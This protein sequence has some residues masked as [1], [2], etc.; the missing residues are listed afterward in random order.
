[1]QC[2]IKQERDQRAKA[3][4][5][6]EEKL[7]AQGLVCVRLVN[8]TAGVVQV[9]LP[10]C[11]VHTRG[12]LRPSSGPICLA[13]QV[14]NLRGGTADALGLLPLV[15]AH[16]LPFLAEGYTARLRASMLQIL[17]E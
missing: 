4:A 5:L 13:A 1:M 15:R 7:Q 11:S 16:S 2:A 17:A 9:C 6:R 12:Y 3:I 10:A 8:R 14:G